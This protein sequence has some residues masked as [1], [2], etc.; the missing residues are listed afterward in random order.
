VGI[1]LD[2]ALPLE[3][4]GASVRLG[5]AF[6]THVSARNLVVLAERA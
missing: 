4:A 2:R 1:A 3:D 6:P 5:T